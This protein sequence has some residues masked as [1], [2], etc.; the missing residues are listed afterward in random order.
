MHSPSHSKRQ[1]SH[2]MHSGPFT[3][4]DFSPRNWNL[5]ATSGSSAFPGKV[6]VGRSSNTFT[7]QTSRQWA[8]PVHLGRAISTETMTLPRSEQGSDGLYLRLEAP[9]HGPDGDR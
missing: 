2:T 3:A 8:H 9:G 5:A 7:G 1:A 6:E 4:T